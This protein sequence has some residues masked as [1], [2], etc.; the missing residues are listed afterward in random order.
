MESKPASPRKSLGSATSRSR[1]AEI[2]REVKRGGKGDEP[3]KEEG[4]PAAAEPHRETKEVKSKKETMSKEMQ[5]EL[6]KAF[7]KNIVKV[8]AVVRG[9]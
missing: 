5:A 8:R 2:K 3:K 9:R 7:S 1:G 6:K 4:A